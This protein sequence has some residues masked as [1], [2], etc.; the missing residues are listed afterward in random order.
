MH[1]QNRSGRSAVSMIRR[2]TILSILLTAVVLRG[3]E[4]VQAETAAE[5]AASAE[6][7]SVKNGWHTADGKTFYYKNG[8]KLTGW[9]KIQGKTYYLTKKGG[10]QKNTIAG[11]KKKGYAYVDADGVRINDKV[12]KRAVS[13]AVKYSKQSKP[14]LQRL[15]KCF[16]ALRKYPYVRYYNDKPSSGRISK[17]ATDML[18]K[19]GGNCYRYASAYAYIARALGYEVRVAVGATT[20][21]RGRSLSPHGWCEVKGGKNWYIVDCSMSRHNKDVDLCL[22]K[23]SKYPFKLRCDKIFTMKIKNHRITWKGKKAPWNNLKSK[24]LKLR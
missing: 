10:L 4:S 5:T 24:K 21:Y 7:D 16:K 14:P 8:K 17:Y 19:K 3:A 22:V 20:A 2:F 1:R 15:E 13:F 18:K 6:A 12:M 11:S 23:R 9:Q